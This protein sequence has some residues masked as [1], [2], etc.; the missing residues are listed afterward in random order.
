MAT[1]YLTSS[2]LIATVKR[3]G[4]IPSSQNTFT[5]AD[6]L[7]IANQELRIGLMPSILQYHE[8]YYVRDSAPIPIVSGVS[9][10]PIPYRAVGGKFREVFYVDSQGQLR[11]MTRISPD[12]RPYYQQA[13]I[14]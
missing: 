8:E 13:N 10:Y 12:D 9:N 5:D 4:M 3:E 6:F 11:S 14:S 2:S 7:Q 1:G